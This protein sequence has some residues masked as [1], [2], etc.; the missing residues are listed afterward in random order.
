VD[1]SHWKKKKE[2][3]KLKL[4]WRFQDGG[5]ARAMKYLLRKAAN[6]VTAAPP[7]KFFFAAVNKVKRR[8]TSHMKLQFKVYLCIFRLV[9]VQYFFT[10]MFSND[11]VYLVILKVYDLIFYFDFIREYS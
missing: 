1:S 9:L 8:W 3:M 10:M 7:Q 2:A 5:D 4:S 6:G 11:N